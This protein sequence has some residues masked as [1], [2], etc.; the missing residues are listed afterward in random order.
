MTQ[1]PQEG[2]GASPEQPPQ[3]PPQSPPPP[4]QEQS[5]QSPQQPG[6]YG[7]PP[8][9]PS[10]QPGYG[11]PQ[12]PEQPGPY[13]PSGPY[14]HSGPYSQQPPQSQPA[15]PG[16]P[17]HPTPQ[18]P[19]PPSPPGPY[20]QPGA[21]PQQPGPY[22]QP[23]QPG[24]YGQSQ[25]PGP[26]GQPGYG[27]PQQPPYPGAP[28]AP[29]IPG[30]PGA[31]ASGARTPLLAR[32]RSRPALAIG[33]AVAAFVVIGAGVFALT[34]GGGDD[35]GKNP[36]VAE[37]GGVKVVKSPPASASASADPDA[38]DAADA[39]ALNADRAAGEAK[40]LW[41]K[42]PPDVPGNGADAPGMWIGDTSVA[43]AAYKQ[44]FGYNVVDQEP[45]WTPITFPQEICAATP[46]M[47]SDGKIIVAYKSGVSERATCNQLQE[48]DLTTGAK[49]WRIKVPEG[50][51]FDG[52]S[53]IGLSLTGRTVVVARSQS[54]IAYDLDTGSKLFEKVQYSDD[55]FPAGFAGGTKLVAVSSC[56]AGSENPHDEVQEL[57]PKTG[58]VEWTHK[59]DKGW[60]VERAYSLDPLVLYST[61]STKNA[62]NISTFTA[63]G[64]V[65]SQVDVDGKFAPE[66]G[67]GVTG[68][69]LQGCRGVA[70][71]AST[72]YL[73]TSV[74][75]GANEI[76]AISLVTGKE[77]WRVKSPVD[78]TMLP[79]RTE[80]GTLFAYVEASADAGSRVVSVATGGAGHK[81]V[82]LLQDPASTTKTENGLYV[83]DFD[84]VDGRFFLSTTQLGSKSDAEA[85]LILVYGK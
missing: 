52:T 26:Y 85:K 19:P 27:Y 44:I 31:P 56:G 58:K 72:L 73:P 37:S 14:A 66:C 84:W 9:Q 17:A 65:R 2:F 67:W 53:T 3:R 54:G 23:Q 8:P 76:V 63:R 13:A 11:Y 70:A 16:Q 62:W 42:N 82:T 1:P 15:Q 33:A 68:R 10:P 32:F 4:Q 46:D 57:N 69:D 74:T 6:G 51:L 35:D 45:A 22:G 25:Q 47:S 38:Q 21:H 61:N 18:S 50:A 75:S 79:I 29:G 30:I 77:K 60:R 43:K 48:V 83:K 41:A 5:Q 64:D 80:G 7:S 55:C 49:G 81:T 39:K 20:G 36:A 71:D 78:E 34:S 28:G 24:P 40:V 59:M 12:A